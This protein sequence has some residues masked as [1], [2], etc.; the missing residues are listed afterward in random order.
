MRDYNKIEEVKVV[1]LEMCEDV[2]KRARDSHQ[3]AR[4]ISLGIGYSKNALVEDFSGLEQYMKLLT[5]QLIYT[6]FA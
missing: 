2:A 1:I 4:T 6:M 5:I 3:A